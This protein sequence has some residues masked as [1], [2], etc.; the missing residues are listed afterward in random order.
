[1]SVGKE[2][3]QWCWMFKRCM[4]ILPFHIP[5]R[6]LLTGISCTQ[7]WRISEAERVKRLK[8]APLLLQHDNQFVVFGMTTFGQ[9]TEG[10]EDSG[11]LLFG[12]TSC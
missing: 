5:L 12:C 3:T 4:L 10:A 11:C 7:A 9:L 6:C 2:G 1:M 8:Y